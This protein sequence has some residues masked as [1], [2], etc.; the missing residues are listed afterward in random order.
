MYEYRFLDTFS[1]K[2][3]SKRPEKIDDFLTESFAEYAN[4]GDNSALL[5]SIARNCMF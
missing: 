1:E 5:F 4:D 3:F 2:Y